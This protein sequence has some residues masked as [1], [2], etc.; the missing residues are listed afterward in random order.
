VIKVLSIV[1]PIA[2]PFQ[3]ACENCHVVYVTI[4]PT[5]GVHCNVCHSKSTIQK[6]GFLCGFITTNDEHVLLIIEGK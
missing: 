1:S 4:S 3:K 2:P 5:H 6:L